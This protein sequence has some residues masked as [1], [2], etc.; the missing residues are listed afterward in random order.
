MTDSDRHNRAPDWLRAEAKSNLRAPI[1]TRARGGFYEDMIHFKSVRNDEV[2][3][4]QQAVH[5]MNQAEGFFSVPA[6][7]R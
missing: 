7:Q 5:D 3:K 1:T 4:Y 6:I 2:E